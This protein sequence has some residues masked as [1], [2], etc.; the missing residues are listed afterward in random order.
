MYL[1]IYLILNKQK[2]NDV[3]MITELIK[4]YIRV[5]KFYSNK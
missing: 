3:K 2:F 1:Q 4:Y 5:P